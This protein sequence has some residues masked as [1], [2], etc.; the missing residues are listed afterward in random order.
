MESEP[1]EVSATSVSSSASTLSYCSSVVTVSFHCLLSCQ[2]TLKYC[3]KGCTTMTIYLDSEE[4]KCRSVK[5]ILIVMHMEQNPSISGLLACQGLKQRS[6]GKKSFVP[7]ATT[8]LMKCLNCIS[9][10]KGCTVE[11][12]FRLPAPLP[13]LCFLFFSL[14]ISVYNLYTLP[15]L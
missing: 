13:P 5:F 15:P 7:A 3:G 4:E 6:L 11:P 9:L 14:Q 8:G 12:P 1:T 2:T 10:Q